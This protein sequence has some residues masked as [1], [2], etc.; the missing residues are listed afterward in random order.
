MCSPVSNISYGIMPGSWV[1]GDYFTNT[2]IK[3]YEFIYIGTVQPWIDNQSH[4]IALDYWLTPE[5][6]KCERVPKIILS[7]NSQAEACLL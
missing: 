1:F 3:S 2:P 5:E 7:G 6:Q 4:W